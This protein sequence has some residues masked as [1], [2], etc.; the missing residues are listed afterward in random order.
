MLIKRFPTLKKWDVLI[1]VILLSLSFIPELIFGIIIGN[2]YSQTYAEITV[3]GTLY[4]K[5]P[6]SEHHGDDQFTIKTADGHYNVVEVKDNAI[7]MID[8]DCPDKDCVHIGFISRPGQPIVCLPHKIIIEIKG[9]GGVNDA[10][11]ISAH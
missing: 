5:V 6:L 9:S 4:K 1:M 2:T 11:I 3:N 7:G 8:S 10:D